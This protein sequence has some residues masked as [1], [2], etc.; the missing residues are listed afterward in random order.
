MVKESDLSCPFHVAHQG[1]PSLP[2]QG[3][4]QALL[5]SCSP[6]LLFNSPHLDEV[7]EKSELRFG[8]LSS[9]FREHSIGLMLVETMAFL[10]LVGMRSGTRPVRVIVY[11]MMEVGRADDQI[12]SSLRQYFNDDFVQL[13][14]KDIPQARQRIVDDRLDFL[15]YAD[16]GMDMCTQL[17]AFS[18]L[19][20]Y[21]GA[22]WGHPITS[23][24]PSVDFFFG[25]D[26]EVLQA[27]E[28]YSEQLVR[29]KFVSSVP[30]IYEKAEVDLMTASDWMSAGL[31]CNSSQQANCPLAAVILG[32]L[33][34]LHPDFI[35]MLVALLGKVVQSDHRDASRIAILFFAERNPYWNQMLVTKLR[36]SLKKNFVAQGVAN[37]TDMVHMAMQHVRLLTYSSAHYEK[38]CRSA[39]MVLDTFPYG[40]K[41]H[42]FDDLLGNK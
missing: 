36:D 22:W 35:D 15:L 19:A 13:H 8:L 32:R 29:M 12:S 2:F 24:L 30:F 7:T 42:S 26:D 17:L 3:Q 21:Q 37:S 41:L 10:R 25:T 18:R 33:F 6:T 1:L 11:S 39:R 34:K 40:G 31:P 16:L 9:Y 5:A 20:I 23:G 14:C 4:W 38:I 28:D 27:N